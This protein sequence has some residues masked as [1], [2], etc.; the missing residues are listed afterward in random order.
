MLKFR[1]ARYR[2]PVQLH[3][4]SFITTEEVERRRQLLLDAQ[5]DASN[6]IQN[7]IRGTEFTAIVVVV[8]M[9]PAVVSL[10]PLQF[11]F[12]PHTVLFL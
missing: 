7:Y 6:V 9:G 10:S 4:F 1:L 3:V 5:P 2:P 11:I 12:P 8:E